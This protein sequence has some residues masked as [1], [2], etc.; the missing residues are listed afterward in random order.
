MAIIVPLPKA[1]RSTC[2]SPATWNA[3]WRSPFLAYATSPASTATPYEVARE[4]GA[5]GFARDES[6]HHLDPRSDDLFAV[7][8]DR[9]LTQQQLRRRKRDE[10]TEGERG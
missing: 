6:H 10:R 5:C 7:G 1:R 4:L 9:R 3:T 2:P 8:V